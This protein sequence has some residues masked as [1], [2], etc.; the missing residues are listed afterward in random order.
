MT[1]TRSASLGIRRYLPTGFSPSKYVRTNAWL[2]IATFGA[3]S[4]SCSVNSRPSTSGSSIARKKFVASPLVLTIG[5]DPE[6]GVCP[7]TAMRLFWRTR[8]RSAVLENVTARTPG[9]VSSL[10]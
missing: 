3:V 7:G 8:D 9:S 10:C 4:L 1:S 6:A 5:N 2:T